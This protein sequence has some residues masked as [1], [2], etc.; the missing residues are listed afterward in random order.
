MTP[1]GEL[2]LAIPLGILK[3]DL[4]WPVAVL[5]AVVG[6]LVPVLPILL[7]L[8][9]G[10]R[11]FTSAANPIA[12]LLAW[13]ADR[14]RSSQGARF[15]KYGAWALVPFVAVPLPLTGAWTGALL[16]WA[17]EV[18]TRKAFLLISLGVLLA[19]VVVTILTE[20][21][22]ALWLLAYEED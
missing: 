8:R 15:Q 13:R 16:A 2:R 18:P 14:L 5:L 4:A 22:S 17:F 9:L 12:R 10:S 20:T 6:N 1:V 21:G 11:L 7:L 19:A 3:Y